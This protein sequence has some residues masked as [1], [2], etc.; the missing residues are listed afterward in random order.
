MCIMDC[1][2]N[3]CFMYVYSG[4]YGEC[5]FYVS[6]YECVHL[7]CVYLKYSR[8]LSSGLRLSTFAL[9]PHRVSTFVRWC[10]V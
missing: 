6:N 7:K 1:M 5:V 3:V 8:E 4:L 9:P 2:G 10:V